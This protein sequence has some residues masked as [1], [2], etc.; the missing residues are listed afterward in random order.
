[1]ERDELQRPQNVNDSCLGSREVCTDL[2][3]CLFAC[4]PSQRGTLASRPTALGTAHSAR[5]RVA[6]CIM[7]SAGEAFDLNCM[8]ADSILVSTVVYC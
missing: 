5:C 6:L 1:M 3:A 2:E 4:L 7:E 8:T